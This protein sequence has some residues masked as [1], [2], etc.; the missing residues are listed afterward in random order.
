MKRFNIEYFTNSGESL[1]LSFD[2]G[3]RVAMHSDDC[4]HWSVEIDADMGSSYGYEVCA[5]DGAVLRKEEF[6]SH[7]VKIDGDAEMF[8]H[9]QDT[10]A[11]KP[12]YSTLFTEGVFRRAER[13]AEL[14]IAD[15]QVIITVAAP[16][17]KSGEKLAIVGETSELGKW[18]VASA[19]IMN[20]SQAPIW[21]VTL[22]KSVEGAE[23]KFVIVDSSTNALIQFEE[24]DNRKIPAS[25]ANRV[26][27]SGLRLR[28]GRRAWRGAT[29]EETKVSFSQIRSKTRM[30]DAQCPLCPPSFTTVS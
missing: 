19:L 17:L 29:K 3:R 20:D 6:G 23:Y 16:T 7:R 2:D 24:G 9:W 11:H 21:S 26:V 12:F 15:N 30:P 14:Q 1:Y 4:T 18:R 28:D 8:D 5:T 25:V 22:P 10:P 27:I 13:D